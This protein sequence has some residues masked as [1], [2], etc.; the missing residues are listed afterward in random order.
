M[1]FTDLGKKADEAAATAK[2]EAAK[3]RTEVGGLSKTTKYIGMGLIGA[4]V[5][6][7]GFCTLRGCGKDKS[8]MENYQQPANAVQAPVVS[9]QPIIVQDNDGIGAGTGFIAGL[10]LGTLID[11]GHG[12]KVP[13][14]GHNGYYDSRYRKP[15]I[16]KTTVINNYGTNAPVPKTATNSNPVSSSVPPAPK[17]SEPAIK[18]ASAW[19][20]NPAATTA[21]PLAVPANVSPVSLAKPVTP[22]PAPVKSSSWFNRPSTSSSSSSSSIS[23]PTRTSFSGSS[24]RSSGSSFRSSSRSGRR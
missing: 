9:P 20:S 8:I 14:N 5:L 3:V 19:G 15:A 1:S 4:L 18:P 21:K 11:D 6:S 10:A 22:P 23:R 17:P 7:M 12:H 16:N 24:F 2:T 13:Y